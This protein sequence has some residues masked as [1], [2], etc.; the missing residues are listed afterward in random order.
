MAGGKTRGAAAQL[1]VDGKTFTDVSGNKTDL[2]PD[3]QRALDDVPKEDRAP[4]HGQCAEVGCL[5]QAMNSGV[6]PTGGNM[7]AV[8]IGD[9]SPG[10]GLPKPPCD[11]C[12]SVN[13]QL[14]INQ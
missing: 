1:E 10:H 4:W 11:S 5:N 2:N 13:R 12:K 6:N 14:G 7:R 9:S 3:L 8:A